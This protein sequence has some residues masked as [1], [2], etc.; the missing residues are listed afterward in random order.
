MADTSLYDAL[1]TGRNVGNDTA[2]C[3]CTGVNSG[4]TVAISGDWVL[5]PEE[6]KF[7]TKRVPDSTD[8]NIRTGS[9]RTEKIYVGYNYESIFN[10]R[11]AATLELDLTYVGADCVL[12]T[13]GHYF[14]K[15][16]SPK[17]QWIAIFGTVVMFDAD[18][19]SE[20]GFVPFMFQ[21]L[22]NKQ[23]VQLVG[24]PASGKIAYPSVTGFTAPTADITI[25]VYTGL[26]GIYK[27]SDI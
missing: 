22:P 17:Q 14:R 7:K 10:Q 12:L 11:D 1:K 20:T 8:F 19:E 3:K 9:K 26:A 18:V 24:T 2:L 27:I 21:G 25:P 23:A 15:L 4:G 16:A 5:L 13:K 6:Q